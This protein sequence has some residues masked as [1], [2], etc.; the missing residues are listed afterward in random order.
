MSI[1][2]IHGSHSRRRRD[3]TCLLRLRPQEV[4][5]SVSIFSSMAIGEASSLVFTLLRD[6]CGQE[7]TF[8]AP[9]F[10]P[11]ELGQASPKKRDE[12]QNGDEPD[13]EPT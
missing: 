2:E 8:S 3:A 11:W 9:Q 1:I 13:G 5:I 7:S 6:P 10:H 4:L 12:H